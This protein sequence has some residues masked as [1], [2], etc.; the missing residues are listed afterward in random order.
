MID[1]HFSTFQTPR[2]IIKNQLRQDQMDSFLEY[3]KEQRRKGIT[4]GNIYLEARAKRKN[5][6]TSEALVISKNIS[7]FTKCKTKKDLRLFLIRAFS[8]YNVEFQT[9]ERELWMELS[10]ENRTKHGK[11]YEKDAE[12]IDALEYS[13][14][15]LY[16]GLGEDLFELYARRKK[17]LTWKTRDFILSIINNKTIEKLSYYQYNDIIQDLMSIFT[18]KKFTRRGRVETLLKRGIPDFIVWHL[19]GF[20]EKPFFVEIKSN[21]SN[22]S[23]HQKELF[24]EL[25]KVANIFIFYIKIPDTMFEVNLKKYGSY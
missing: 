7:E 4:F 14:S 18:L 20:K 25:N 19:Y 15:G 23:P 2:K 9:L 5:L 8:D 17:W 6:T 12:I 10:K 21:T 1:Y 22:I 3:W 11:T 16:G 13:A 24:S